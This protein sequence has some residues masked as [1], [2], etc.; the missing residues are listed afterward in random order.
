MD[1]KHNIN[2]ALKYYRYYSAFCENAVDAMEWY[3]G[4]ITIKSFAKSITE[5]RCLTLT[6][7]THMDRALE[8][9]KKLCIQE[10]NI[11]KYNI[12]M[13]KYIDPPE[14]CDGKG[15]PF[16]NEHLADL[17][18]C[19]AETI[20]RDVSKA[21]SELKILFFGFIPEKVSE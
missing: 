20:K 6:Y 17:F 12:I 4:D 16:S 14:G 3:L 11:R 1:I 15:K 19:S 2:E 7:K 5:S 9:Y 10:K 13:R 18:D 21:K 8:A